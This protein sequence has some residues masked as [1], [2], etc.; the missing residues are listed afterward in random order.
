MKSNIAQ[1]QK[2]FANEFSH[3]INFNAQAIN[4]SDMYLKLLETRYIGI[5]CMSSYVH[6]YVRHISEYA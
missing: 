2:Y 6:K 5:T 4:N 1:L 3:V